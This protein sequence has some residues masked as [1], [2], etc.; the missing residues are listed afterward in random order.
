MNHAQK[1]Y[2]EA[3]RIARLAFPPGILIPD[4]LPPG[5]ELDRYIGILL[6]FRVRRYPGTPKWYMHN[7]NPAAGWMVTLRLT[8]AE[9]YDDFPNF[10]TN[11]DDRMLL[12]NTLAFLTRIVGPKFGEYDF[13]Q[14]P[15]PAYQICLTILRK[16]AP[17]D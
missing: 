13:S 7:P 5:R 6:G 14:V 3:Q 12:W 8:K 9:A 16:V 15:D 10:S 11:N 4:F 17:H 2:K 1:K